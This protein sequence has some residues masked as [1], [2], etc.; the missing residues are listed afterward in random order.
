MRNHEFPRIIQ[1]YKWYLF[2]I[3]DGQVNAQKDECKN[4]EPIRYDERTS[5]HD[6]INLPRII[7]IYA[8]NYPYDKKVASF[9]VRL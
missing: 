3:V 1:Q 6:F 9:L 5:F 8:L 4:H 7:N 2:L